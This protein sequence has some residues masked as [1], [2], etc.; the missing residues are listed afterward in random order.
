MK[1]YLAHSL[2]HRIKIRRWQ[3]SV[4]KIFDLKFINPFYNNQ[5]ERKEIKILDSLGTKRE[6]D[7]YQQSWTIKT[8]NKIVDI[9]LEL[10]RMSNAVVAYFEVV[11]IGT[12]Q[13]IIIT[14]YI[15]RMPVY[16]ITKNYGHHCWLRSL[17]DRSHGK[18]FK[19]RAEFKKY[20]EKEGLRKK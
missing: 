9:D 16:V 8:C 13:E 10:I 17:V 11:T 20:L 6:R 7:K 19:T 12:I 14:A 15:Y 4:E 3:L 5:H 2:I 1:F 18:I